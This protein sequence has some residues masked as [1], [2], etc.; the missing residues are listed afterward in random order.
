MTLT[1]IMQK[2]NAIPYSTLQAFI[3]ESYSIEEYESFHRRSVK[4]MERH[5]PKGFRIDEIL[6]NILYGDEEMIVEFIKTHLK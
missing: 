1:E 5:D 6:S 4:N 2:M 3:E